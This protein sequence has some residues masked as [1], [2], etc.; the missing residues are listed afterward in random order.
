MDVAFL[1]R[2]STRTYVTR[3][4]DTVRQP[5]ARAIS[6]HRTRRTRTESRLDA[7]RKILP[8]TENGRELNSSCWHEPTFILE[9][10][11][12][13]NQTLF[14]FFFQFI[15]ISAQSEYFYLYAAIL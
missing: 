1:R 2:E 3:V 5:Y 8:R 15:F 13:A 10:C 9:R 6:F 7:K 14:F 11:L 12:N 4:P